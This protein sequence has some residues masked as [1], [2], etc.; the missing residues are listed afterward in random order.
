MSS[1]D[2]TKNDGQAAGIICS[3]CG[4]EF[5]RENT[6]RVNEE[7]KPLCIPCSLKAVS[8]TAS[9]TSKESTEQHKARVEASTEKREKGK[10]SR[11]VAILLLIA[12]PVIAFEAFLL[13]KNKPAGLTAPE[14]AQIELSECM[15][16]MTVLGQ[17]YDEQGEYPPDLGTLVPEFWS[18]ADAEELNRY[19]Y[20]RIGIDNFRLERSGSPLPAPLISNALA[21][22]L[23]PATMTAETSIDHYIDRIDEEE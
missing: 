2:Q 5:P 7:G 20:T 9:A 8:A 3:S 18:S 22:D 12:L 13:F 14:V 16:M 17:Y 19:A 4:T 23:L 6:G 1:E 15:I 11:L 10:G 21:Q